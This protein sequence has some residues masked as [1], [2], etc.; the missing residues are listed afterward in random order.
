MRYNLRTLLIL[1]AVLP[2]LIAFPL[3]GLALGLVATL[4]SLPAVPGL[5]SSYPGPVM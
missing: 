2:P 4:A 3:F 5:P 1:M